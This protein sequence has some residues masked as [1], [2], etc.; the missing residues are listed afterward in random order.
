MFIKT[1]YAMGNFREEYNNN[2]K[3]NS[4]FNTAKNSKVVLLTKKAML[5]VKDTVISLIDNH[6][7]LTGLTLY[8]FVIWLYFTISTSSIVT[9]TILILLT[10]IYAIMQII[11]YYVFAFIVALSITGIA[12]LYKKYKGGI[13]KSSK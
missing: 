6:G 4:M 2:Q 13:H 9:G 12:T 3:W 10:A 11:A 7:I 8:F 5:K 1:V